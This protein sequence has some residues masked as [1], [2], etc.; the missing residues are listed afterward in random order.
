MAK[1]LQLRKNHQETS[2]N[3]NLNNNF[4]LNFITLYIENEEFADISFEQPTL[5]CAFLITPEVLI[6]KPE[7]ICIYNVKINR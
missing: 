1:L 3:S 2:N 7:T 6:R 4:N 5:R